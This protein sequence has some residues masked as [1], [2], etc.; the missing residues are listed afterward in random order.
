MTPQ[1][2]AVQ[3]A[4]DAFWYEHYTKPHT[5]KQRNELAAVFADKWID[6]SKIKPDKVFIRHPATQRRLYDHSYT[7]A[8]VLADFIMRVDQV[9]ER[10]EEFP[11]SNPDHDVNGKFKRRER[12][13][14][15]LFRDDE[16]QS[17]EETK[18]MPPYSVKVND[19]VLPNSIEDIIFAETAPDVGVF[20]A[21]LRKVKKFAEFYATTFAEE[22]GYDKQ[23]ALRGIKRLDLSRIREC[24]I[25][26]SAFY[27]HDLRR[28]VCDMQRGIMTRKEKG[29]KPVYEVT[30]RSTCEIIRDNKKAQERYLG[31]KKS[32]I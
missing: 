9:K 17:P 20:R 3:A 25:C 14:F 10:D 12:E 31:E 30:E 11:I 4:L 29:K 6:R 2:K 23:E 24:E 5:S 13:R 19:I 27:A 8:E 32:I 21:Q 16:D 22:Y 1:E 7:V 18:P 15:I 26:G 28:H